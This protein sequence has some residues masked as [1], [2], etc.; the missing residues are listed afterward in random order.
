MKA[1]AQLLA[2]IR[3]AANPGTV[4]VRFASPYIRGTEVEIKTHKYTRTEE[5]RLN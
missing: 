1:P 3:T 2:Y 4:K 5:I